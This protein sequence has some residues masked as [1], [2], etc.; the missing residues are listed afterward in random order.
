MFRDAWSDI[1]GHSSYKGNGFG[2]LKASWVYVEMGLDTEIFLGL[3][4]LSG[5]TFPANQDDASYGIPPR[6]DESF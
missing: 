3:P 1:T 6:S 2:Y 5:T 4:Y